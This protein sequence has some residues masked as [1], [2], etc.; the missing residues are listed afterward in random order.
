MLGGGAG[1][2]TTGGQL[3]MRTALRRFARTRRY[4]TRFSQQDALLARPRVIGGFGE[5]GH[6]RVLIGSRKPSCAVRP[7]ECSHFTAMPLVGGSRAAGSGD[8]KAPPYQGFLMVER[9]G[10]EPV[11]SG[12]QSR[13]LTDDER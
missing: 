9:T 12:L 2:G 7:D 8:K 5:C 10:I 3:P 6:S 13:D 4:T 1:S 11:T